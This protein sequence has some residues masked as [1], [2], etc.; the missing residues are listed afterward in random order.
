MQGM[1]RMRVC[2]ASLVQQHAVTWYGKHGL[3]IS[4]RVGVRVPSIIQ[5]P[6]NHALLLLSHGCDLRCVVSTSPSPSRPGPR[7]ASTPR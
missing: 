7:Q 6:C 4:T 1:L 2:H 3:L 5:R